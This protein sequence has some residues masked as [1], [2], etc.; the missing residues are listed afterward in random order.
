MNVSERVIEFLKETG[1]R[2]GA[3]RAEL[4][5]S[6]A[7]GDCGERSDYDVVFYGV[8]NGVARAEIRYSAEWEAPTLLNIDVL[9]GDELSAELAKSIKN[10]GVIIY[11]SAKA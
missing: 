2:H 3:E 11:E 8:E 9:F 4:F 7:R 6:R 5:G 10:D 1:R